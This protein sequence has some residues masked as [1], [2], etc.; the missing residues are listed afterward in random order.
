MWRVS[1]PARHTVR[2]P[3]RHC[4]PNHDRG[5]S[6]VRGGK[7]GGFMRQLVMF[8]LLGGALPP[9]M[10]QLVP[11]LPQK[12]A[13]VPQGVTVPKG[14]TLFAARQKDRFGEERKMIYLRYRPVG[15]LA[16]IEAQVV[17]GEP[18]QTGDEGDPKYEMDVC[19]IDWATGTPRDPTIV[20]NGGDENHT[21]CCA[22]DECELSPCFPNCLA[23]AAPAPASLTAESLAGTRQL[24]GE[25][26]AM[27]QAMPFKKKFAPE[28][29]ALLANLASV[30]G[31][32]TA[33]TLIP[34][35]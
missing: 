25:T 34:L 23:A 21:F 33:T 30:A 8:L 32:P 19:I 17:R 11:D 35:R 14:M 26:L 1:T 31:S 4:E 27:V 7:D 20:Q 6:P 13:V 2:N 15:R 5:G 28:R 9:A 10:A 18:N 24:A 3:F 12:I 29:E 22:D 16:G